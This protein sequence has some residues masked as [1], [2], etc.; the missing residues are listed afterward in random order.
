MTISV[1]SGSPLV[2]VPV[3]SKTIVS[4]LWAV[5]KLSPPLIKIPFS[6]PLPVPT[7]TAVGV[8]NPR[9][10]GQAIIITATKVKR[11]KVKGGNGPKLNHMTKVAMAIEITIG[12]K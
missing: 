6:A 10:Q 9:A 3:L 1:I 8:A 2:K 5:S 7:I 12:T 11:A 4:S